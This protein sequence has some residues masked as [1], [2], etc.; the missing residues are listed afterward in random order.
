MFFFFLFNLSLARQVTFESHLKSALLTSAFF[1]T[2]FFLYLSHLKM[3]FY[4]S[5]LLGYEQKRSVK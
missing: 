1:K 3:F 4:C 2:D 5:E